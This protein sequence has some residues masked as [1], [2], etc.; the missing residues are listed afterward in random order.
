MDR[1]PRLSFS[2]ELLGKL[3]TRASP[4]APVSRPSSVMSCLGCSN[5]TSMEASTWLLLVWRL[6]IVI[7]WKGEGLQEEILSLIYTQWS[8]CSDY[9]QAC[10]RWSW[11]TSFEVRGCCLCA[12]FSFYIA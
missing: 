10:A 5:S 11:C 6:L 2:A 7:C 1:N 12:T 8:S 3:V 4:D 9:S